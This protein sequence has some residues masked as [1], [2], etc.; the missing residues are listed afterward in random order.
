MLSTGVHFAS[1]STLD[2]GEEFDDPRTAQSA[3]RGGTIFALQRV[4]LKAILGNVDANSDIF[5]HGRPPS[6]WRSSDH[7]S[8]L[9]CPVGGAVHIIKEGKGAIR[10]TR[11]SC[12]SFAANAV[13]LQLHALAYNLGNF[14]RTF[15]TPE[16]I[17]RRVADEPQGETH[18][19]WREGRQ[20]WA[21]CRVPDG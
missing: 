9:R 10:W 16:P 21:L 4:D 14:L 18:Q 13:R 11:L 17:K 7:L 19:D 20:P 1:E 3:F 8:A 2:L 15:A 12:H 6:W 5:P